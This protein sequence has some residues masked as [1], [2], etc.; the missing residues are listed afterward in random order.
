MKKFKI[1]RGLLNKLIPL[2]LLLG[3]LLAFAIYCLVVAI[4][5]NIGGPKVFSSE[6]VVNGL[7]E[8]DEDNIERIDYDK[9]TDFDVRFYASSY[10]DADEK[11]VYFQVAFAKKEN[12]I[13]PKKD[14]TTYFKIDIA[15]GAEKVNFESYYSTSS[16]IDIK[17]PY[18][19]LDKTIEKV[20]TRKLKVNCDTQFP[21]KKTQ[22]PITV[23]ADSP[24]AYLY[25][26]YTSTENG[27]DI[28]KEYILKYTY[29]DYYITAEE[30]E[31][32]NITA[33]TGGIIR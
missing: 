33:T 21:A 18:V 1:T 5:L 17:S 19:G 25:L 13:L 27:V 8:I 29:D 23:K 22:W 32:L 11:A 15:L 24:D 16:L 7:T 20:S 6:S 12:G 4:K 10:D 14:G 3:I 28:K 26:Q 30:A 2:V 9:F 31:E